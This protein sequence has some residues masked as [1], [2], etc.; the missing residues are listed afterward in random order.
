M[1]AEN[2]WKY[3]PLLSGSM[4]YTAFVSFTGTVYVVNKK[5]GISFITALV[6]A[7]TNIALNFILIPSPL[8]VQGAA[9][10]TVTSYFI[11]FVIRAFNVRKYIPFKMRGLQV[12]LNSVIVFAQA[13]VMVLE[14]KYWAI[15]Q[16]LC[17]VLLF[18]INYK[19]LLESVSDIISSVL[20]RKK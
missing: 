19:L 2:L 7:A 14:I 5:S 17:I 11:V 4:V 10:A 1:T 3:V 13:T 18:V 8:G 12:T 20:R 9:I 15:I 16:A 6:G